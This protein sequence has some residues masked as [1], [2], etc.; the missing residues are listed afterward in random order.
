MAG[1]FSVPPR[2]PRSC[3]PPLKSGR[4]R[5]PFLAQSPPAPFGPPNLCPVNESRSTP[6]APGRTGIFPTAWTASVWTTAPAACAAPAASGIRTFT[7]PVSLLARMSDTTAVFASSADAS[8][9]SSGS[10]SPSTGTSTGSKPS[11]ARESP[12]SRTAGCSAAEKTT[13]LRP[14]SR[15]RAARAAPLTARV[16]DSVPPEVKTIS[17]GRTPRA[18]ATASRADSTAFLAARPGAWI[19]EGLA[20]REVSH[21]SIASSASGRRGVVAW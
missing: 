4:R 3:P 11:S 6:S 16:S 8:P 2:R 14:G 21:G 20:A 10:P 12:A 7:A 13:R 19:E 5:T 17:S 9:S 1:T 15:S 18:D